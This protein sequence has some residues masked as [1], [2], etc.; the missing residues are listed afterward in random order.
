VVRI[1]HDAP[2]AAVLMDLP[3]NRGRSRATE[4]DIY[5]TISVTWVELLIGFAPPLVALSFTV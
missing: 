3:S 5:C 4:W 1:A 2:C